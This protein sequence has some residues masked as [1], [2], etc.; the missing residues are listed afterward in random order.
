MKTKYRAT[1]YVVLVMV[2]ATLLYTSVYHQRLPW[3]SP[4]EARKM[5]VSF[6][7]W[8]MIALF[9][10]IALSVLLP[11]PSSPFV[12]AGGYVYGTLT[13]GIIAIVASL[14]G[15]VCAFKLVRRFGRPV[16]TY[17]V[18]EKQINH[19]Y[20][21]FKNRGA[22]AIILFYALPILPSDTVSFLLGLTKI[23]I[24]IFLTLITTGIIPRMFLL[25]LFGESL[26]RGITTKTIV[27]GSIILLFLLATFFRRKIAHMLSKEAKFVEHEV[28]KLFA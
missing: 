27:L 17:F 22:N 9:F 25:T 23:R 19:F 8:G 2:L 26:Y 6:G 7:N 24:R 20:R 28:E 21:L 11:L 4:E 5:I 18:D 15:G 13:S 16:V 3:S 1:G 14:L 12:I 10:F